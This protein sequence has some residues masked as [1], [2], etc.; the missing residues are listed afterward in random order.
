[1]IFL[2]VGTQLPFDRLAKA[3][4]DVARET[5][6]R[7]VGQIG[8]TAFRPVAY[9]ARADVPPV[10]FTELVS[11]ARVLI[12]HAGVGTILAAM[13]HEKPLILMA[14]RSALGEHR[15]DHQVHTCARMKETPGVYVV[16]TADEIRRLLASDLSPMRN[17][18]SPMRR[19]LIERMKSAL[20]SKA[21]ESGQGPGTIRVT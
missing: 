20:A 7:I 13:Q 12:A 5:E 10:E 1:M 14:R 16:E 3:V 8:V 21:S 17:S 11:S 15:N 18:G 19:Q 6:E 2:T 4:E 9:E